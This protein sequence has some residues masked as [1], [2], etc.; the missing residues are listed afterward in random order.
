MKAYRIYTEHNSAD[1]MRDP[2]DIHTKEL[3]YK[4][5]KEAAI[6]FMKSYI[7]EH[8]FRPEKVTIRDYK[9]VY[10]AVNAVSYGAVLYAKEIEIESE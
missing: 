8:F 9:D 1:T 4:S 3:C 10:F 5:T 7:D 6:S 2:D